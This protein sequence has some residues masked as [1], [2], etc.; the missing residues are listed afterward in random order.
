MISDSASEPPSGTLANPVDGRMIR[1]FESDEVDSGGICLVTS[2]LFL[3]LEHVS[4]DYGGG[5]ILQID[6]ERGG[7][8]ISY[9]LSLSCEEPEPKPPA[10]HHDGRDRHPPFT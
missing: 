7:D 4:R 6:G 3:I 10:R 8:S 5:F 9:Y 2:G 1:S